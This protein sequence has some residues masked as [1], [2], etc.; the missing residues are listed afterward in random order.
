LLGRRRVIN[1]L[2]KVVSRW[3]R[4]NGTRRV[5][6][7]PSEQQ[8]RLPEH[9]GA[10]R[11]HFAHA[12]D[13]GN[14]PDESL[15]RIPTLLDRGATEV[16]HRRHLDRGVSPSDLRRHRCPAVQGR[17]RR[18][19]GRCEPRSVSIQLLE[20]EEPRA[21]PENPAPDG[22]RDDASALRDTRNRTSVGDHRRDGVDD[23]LHAG[24]LSGKR[25]ER[26]QSLAVPTIAA[27]RQRQEKRHERV[28]RLEPSRHPA[29]GQSELAPTARR[30][31]T[32][33]ED[34]VAAIDERGVVA[35]LDVEY[36]NHVLMAA[37]GWV[38]LTGAA[39]LL[40]RTSPR[41][42]NCRELRDDETA[43]VETATVETATVETAT[44]G[45]ASVGTA[46]VGTAS[47]GTASVETTNWDE[48]LNE[49]ESRHP[50]S[51]A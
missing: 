14:E 34:V 3:N 42:A 17:A 9:R 33:H 27:S 23:D 35:R 19:A 6:S 46:S 4:R 47:V 36:E 45:T 37:P 26:K 21:E 51:D 24:D 29:A 41:S 5:D 32:A 10:E 44:V 50:T 38:K 11:R 12:A 1:Y 49:R 25:I 22:A 16:R 43:T 20:I 7:M 30:T 2:V 40:W 28:A 13:A 15:R 18:T 48:D 39:N 31:A 8:D